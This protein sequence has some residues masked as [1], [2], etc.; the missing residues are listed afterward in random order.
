[1]SKG[2]WVTQ[3]ATLVEFVAMLAVFAAV[4]WYL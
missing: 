3:L 2:G 4:I 1:M